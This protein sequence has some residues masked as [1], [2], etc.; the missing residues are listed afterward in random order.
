[1]VT[2]AKLERLKKKIP[3]KKYKP[4]YVLEEVDGQ[5][6]DPKGQKVTESEKENLLNRKGETVVLIDDINWRGETLKT[7]SDNES[8]KREFE[9]LNDI[10]AKNLDSGQYLRAYSQILR[11]QK[12]IIKGDE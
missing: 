7:L 10:L 11:V 3:F 6:I 12:E 4:V 5:L 1:M 8:Y 9:V 2:K